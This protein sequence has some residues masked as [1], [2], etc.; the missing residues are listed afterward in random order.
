MRC[1]DRMKISELLSDELCYWQLMGEGAENI[2]TRHNHQWADTNLDRAILM[3]RS[4][5]SDL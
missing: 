3:N 1:G 2:N 4:Q 5:I